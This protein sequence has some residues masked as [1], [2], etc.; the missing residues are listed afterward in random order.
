M[1]ITTTNIKNMP[2]NQLSVWVEIGTSTK[3]DFWNYLI[4]SSFNSRLEFIFNFL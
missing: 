2:E 3:V 4:Y 1:T